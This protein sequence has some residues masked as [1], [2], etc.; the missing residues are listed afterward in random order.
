MGAG[1]SVDHAVDI[2]EAKAKAG[3]SWDQAKWDGLSK[4]ADGKVSAA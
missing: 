2:E 3:D 4:D 1:A